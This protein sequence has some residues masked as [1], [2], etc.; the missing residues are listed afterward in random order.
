[1]SDTTTDTPAAPAAPGPAPRSRRLYSDA[2]RAAALAALDANGGNVKRTARHL[3]I[4]VKT[5]SGWAKGRRGT[6]TP[7]QRTEA[8]KDLLA[9]LEDF[10]LRLVGMDPRTFADL[11]FKDVCVGL[12][13]T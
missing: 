10:A 2:E 12:G 5:L 9:A 1:M 11:S 13:I 3:S 8:R 7:E 4:T 6:I